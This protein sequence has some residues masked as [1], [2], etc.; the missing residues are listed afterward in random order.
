MKKRYID[1]AVS[2]ICLA[3]AGITILYQDQVREKNVILII[4]LLLFIVFFF[5]FINGKRN[6]R[7]DTK[8]SGARLSPEFGFITELALLSEE[9]KAL[10]T[11]DLY[12]KTSVVIGRD[13]KEN[14]VD[15]DLG[16]SAYASMVDIEH[17][18]LNFSAGH[19]YVED[20]GS[21]NGISVKKAEDG[22]TYRL[23]A[24]TP[25]QVGLGDCLYVGLNRLL[26][27]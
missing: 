27:R 16:Q 4:F 6:R 21:A 5:S 18:V 20:L 17:A 2:C 22:R 14:Q 9:D 19:W 7:M 15:I 25:C 3:A 11:W 13:C 23:S 12:G 26:F 8:G 10:I 1:L 24:D